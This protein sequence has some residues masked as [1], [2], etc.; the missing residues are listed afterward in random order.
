MNTA[1]F[2]LFLL[3]ILP[4]IWT[5][6]FCVRQGAGT[7]KLDKRREATIKAQNI[8]KFE[9]DVIDRQVKVGMTDR[10]VLAAWGEP[11]LVHEQKK[12]RKQAEI[13]LTY[14]TPG[15]TGDANLITLRDGVVIDTVIN[16]PYQIAVGGVVR[17]G[18][19]LIAILFMVW[20]IFFC[21]IS[22]GFG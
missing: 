10:M 5:A 3:V 19:I 16:Q 20:A 15:S 7:A 4:A 18:L 12:S 22:I 2:L 17:Q 6:V 8:G 21:M 11:E 9:Q 13:V 1:V 14:G